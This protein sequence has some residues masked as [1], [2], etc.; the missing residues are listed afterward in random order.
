V[1]GAVLLLALICGGLYMIGQGG[2][3]PQPTATVVSREPTPL[4]T[5]TE[6]AA[7]PSPTTGEPDT[8]VRVELSRFKKMYDDPAQRPLILDVRDPDTYRAGHIAGA[9]SFPEAEVDARAGELPKDQ[10]IIA[11]C[12]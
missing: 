6:E 12:Q 10:V 1:A 8:L 9:V 2:I 5:S 3:K 4:P 11:Y 7:L